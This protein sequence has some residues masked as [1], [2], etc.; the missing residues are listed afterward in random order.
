VK[1]KGKPSEE[2]DATQT[3]TRRHKAMGE[4]FRDFL[5]LGGASRKSIKWRGKRKEEKRQFVWTVGKVE[6]EQLRQRGFCFRFLTST[7][8]LL[9]ARGI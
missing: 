8:T 5:F 4:K 9:N 7:A 2:K 3:K 6:I 1:G